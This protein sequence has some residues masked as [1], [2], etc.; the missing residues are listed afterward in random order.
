MSESEELFQE[1]VD[2]LETALETTRG[3]VTSSNIG[4]AN[5]IDE[6]IRKLAKS[7]SD[8]KCIEIKAEHEVVST[9]YKNFNEF[10]ESNKILTDIDKDIKSMLKKLK[11]WGVDYQV[12]KYISSNKLIYKIRAYVLLDKIDSK[13]IININKN[14]YIEYFENTIKKYGFETYKYLANQKNTIAYGERFLNG[15]LYID[16]WQMIEGGN[17][18]SRT[19]INNLINDI[20]KKENSDVNNPYHMER[21]NSEA[22]PKIKI[23]RPL[24]L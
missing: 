20:I 3:V 10:S 2:H 22:L 11:M 8:R 4:Y 7:K 9:I 16:I 14:Q 15:N 13:S 19:S 17:Q 23:S 24:K 1:V 21:R 18:L 5:T 6:P 12:K